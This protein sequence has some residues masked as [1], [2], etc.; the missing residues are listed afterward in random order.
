M[1]LY[2]VLAAAIL[3]IV[4]AIAQN[5]ALVYLPNS[6]ASISAYNVNPNDGTLTQISGSPFPNSGGQSSYFAVHPSKKFLYV[7][8]SNNLAISIY[9]IDPQTGALTMVGISGRLQS[10]T[11]SGGRVHW[12]RPQRTIPL[13]GH[14]V[15]LAH[16]RVW[17][18]H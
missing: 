13:C 15:G 10:H 9:S 2:L 14:S 1:K 11:A 18:D 7:A 4:P 17:L 5:T 16:Q 8:D 6:G 3:M 12:H